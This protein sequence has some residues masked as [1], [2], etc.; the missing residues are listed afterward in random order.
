MLGEQEILAATKKEQATEIMSNNKEKV[1]I[2]SAPAGCFLSV[3]PS[4]VNHLRHCL[5]FYLVNFEI[6]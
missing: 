1:S 6:V 4:C 5:I 3:L 2:V